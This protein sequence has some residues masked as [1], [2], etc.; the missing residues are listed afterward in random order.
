MKSKETI[1]WIL[2]IVAGVTLTI[3]GVIF[4]YLYSSAQANACIEKLGYFDTSVY[5]PTKYDWCLWCGAPL[6]FFGLGDILVCII[7]HFGY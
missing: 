4:L 2:L 3:A 5:I 1:I 7:I 6:L